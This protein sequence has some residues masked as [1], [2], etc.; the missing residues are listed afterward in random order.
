M[1]FIDDK[2]RELMQARGLVDFQSIWSEVLEPVD[3]PNRERGG[4]SSVCR[5][6]LIDKQGKAHH[7]YL[8]RQ[9]NHLSYSLSA[10]FGEP[11]FKREFRNILLYE[12]LGIATV[13]P[14]YF[15]E[16]R[17]NSERRAIL[18]T[19]ALDEFQPLSEL[20]NQW[21][22]LPMDDRQQVIC[23]VAKSVARLHKKKIVHNCLYPKHIYMAFGEEP[24]VRFI[25][26]EKSRYQWLLKRDVITDLD[27]LLRRLR[28][29]SGEEK[30]YFLESYLKT[31]PVFSELAPMLKRID[32]RSEDKRRR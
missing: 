15:A 16:Q 20:H 12:R 22:S 4:L 3:K 25:D 11:T 5:L 21:L 13:L 18:I 32:R 17:M 26:L 10:P 8:K 9:S 31:N 7:Y 24:S 28:N 30:K 23:L 14:V 27:A 6:S 2:F 1:G 29:W 19:K